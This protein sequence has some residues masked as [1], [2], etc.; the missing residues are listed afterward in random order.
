MSS[1]TDEQRDETEPPPPS[2]S[3]PST[4]PGTGP[5]R[6]RGALLVALACLVGALAGIG[7]YTFFYA[8]GISYFSTEP[9]ACVNCHIMRPQY[10]AWQKSSHH[11]VAVC[12]DCHLPHDFVAKYVAKAENGY[13]HSKEFTTQTFAEPIFV[14]E[15]GR[16]ILE[17]NCRYCHAALVSQMM[18][19]S[20]GP[21]DR[22]SCV[23]C[24][25]GVGHGD[26]AR[27]GGKLRPEEIRKVMSHE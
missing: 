7:G 15:R 17:D 6:A 26:A 8:E 18:A 25:A 13:R 2:A 5:W 11:T 3:P 16:E 24:H 9:A 23:Q 1:E 20:D 14:K 12:I 27:L 22:I 4:R 21:G 19:L 10:D